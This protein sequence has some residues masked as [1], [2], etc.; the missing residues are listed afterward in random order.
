MSNLIKLLYRFRAVIAFMILGTVAFIL[1]FNNTYY[2][3]TQMYGVFRQMQDYVYEKAGSIAEYMTLKEDNDYLT[4]E[5]TAL[6][7]QL[8]LYR[9][10]DSLNPHRTYSEY[11][12]GRRYTYIPARVANLSTSKQK[13]YIS[14]NVGSNH[15]VHP[16]MGVVANNSVVGVV[17]NTS[18][19]FSTVMPIINR[20]T[21][22]S[23]RLKRSGHFGSL[24]WDGVYYR[25][26]LLT[27]VPQHAVVVAGDT[28]VT[29]GFSGIF[30]EDM[31]IGT[32]ID[33]TVKRGSFY[34]IRIRL[35]TDFNTLRHVK[36]INNILQME[37]QVLEEQEINF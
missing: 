36:V 34:E 27:E 4:T 19:N 22:I 33:Y 1:I 16:D 18:A 14:I 32:V 5:N 10:A 31:F 21:K 29:S 12:A 23:A 20:N 8:M 17:V 7:N 9:N 30:P 15:H 2:Q 26:A 13:N 25:E 37:Q 3:Q 28:V 11:F 35:S 6:L 24:M